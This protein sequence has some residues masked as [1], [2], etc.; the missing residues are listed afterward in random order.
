MNYTVL[1]DQKIVAAILGII[2]RYYL[3]T[4]AGKNQNTPF[5]LALDT[6]KILVNKLEIRV[7]YLFLPS[8]TVRSA[9]VKG[10]KVSAAFAIHDDCAPF[11]C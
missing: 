1:H 8:V 3:L 4:L 9:I 11:P 7:R 6:S 5:P 2:F 10:D